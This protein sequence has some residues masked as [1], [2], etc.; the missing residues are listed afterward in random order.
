MRNALQ[1]QPDSAE[2]LQ[3]LGRTL[4]QQGSHQKAIEVFSK[5]SKLRPDNSQV[6]YYLACGHIGAGNISEARAVANVS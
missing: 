2:I 6:S 3:A 5:A 1:H 4:Q